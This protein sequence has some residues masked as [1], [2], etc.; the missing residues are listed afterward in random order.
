MHFKAI[1][2]KRKFCK[3]FLSKEN[4]A[5]RSQTG[6]LLAELGVIRRDKRT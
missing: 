6:R 5:K 3:K 4:K 2:V 1:K